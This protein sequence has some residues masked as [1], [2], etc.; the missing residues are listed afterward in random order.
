MVP[1]RRRLLDKPRRFR[2]QPEPGGRRRDGHRRLWRAV[3]TGGVIGERLSPARDVC[4]RYPAC[5]AFVDDGYGSGTAMA[6]PVVDAGESEGFQHRR[7]ATVADDL[8]RRSQLSEYFWG[9]TQARWIYRAKVWRRAA[10]DSV[11]SCYRA[12]NSV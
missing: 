2:T 6:V 10:A 7:Q 3:V 11:T 12:L 5:D 9:T 4:D 1:L 8:R